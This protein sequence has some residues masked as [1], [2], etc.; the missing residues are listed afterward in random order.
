MEESSADHLS[1]IPSGRSHTFHY[2]I[3]QISTS[4]CKI[5][6]LKIIKRPIDRS[7]KKKIFLTDFNSEGKT[8]NFGGIEH[9]VSYL[10]LIFKENFQIHT[11]PNKNNLKSHTSKKTLSD[12]LPV[13]VNR[14]LKSFNLTKS[15]HCI[16]SNDSYRNPVISFIRKGH[17]IFPSSRLSWHG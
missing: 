11:H 14:N 13:G 2:E 9:N 6:R 5:W 17:P 10:L 8:S 16:D 3:N 15:Q 1:C 4:K 12:K 7:L